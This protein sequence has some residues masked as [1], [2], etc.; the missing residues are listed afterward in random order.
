MLSYTFFCSFLMP[1]YLSSRAAF[2]TRFLR[3]IL[4]CRNPKATDLQTR[5]RLLLA[6]S[7]A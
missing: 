4:A 6:A 5:V 7:G 1:D 2:Q 3:S